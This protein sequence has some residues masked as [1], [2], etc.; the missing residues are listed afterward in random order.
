MQGSLEEKLEMI[1]IVPTLRVFHRAAEEAGEEE[2]D[3][4]L[5]NEELFREYYPEYLFRKERSRRLLLDTQNLLIDIQPGAGTALESYK[6]A[7]RGMD[8]LKTMEE[9]RALELDNK[10]REHLLEKQ[11][12]EAK[13]WPG[14]QKVVIFDTEEQ[15]TNK[16]DEK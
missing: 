9:K 8:V 6:L 3:D 14:A 2:L 11:K 4:F 1:E 13:Y 15:K 12:Y 5:N 16:K 10:R 7:H